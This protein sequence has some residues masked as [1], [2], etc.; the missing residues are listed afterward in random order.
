MSKHRTSAPR[1]RGRLALLAATLAVAA[2]TVATGRSVDEPPS[3]DAAAPGEP[4]SS[5]AQEAAAEAAAEAGSGAASAPGEAAA[6][7]PAEDEIVDLEPFVVTPTRGPRRLEQAPSLTSLITAADILE[8]Q[9]RT[10]PEALDELPGVMVQK[11]GHGQGSPFI[12]GFTGFRNLLLIDGIRLNNSVFRDGPNQYWNTI[13]PYSI[14]RLEVVKGPGSVLYG[15]DAIGGTVNVLTTGPLLAGEGLHVGGRGFYRLS[16]AER[17]H[18]Y[19]GSVE[20]VQ[21]G[22]VG[23]LV[24]GTFRDY[25][26]LETGR[27]R[28]P[29]TG[30]EELDFDAKLEWRID[31]GVRLV[32]AHQRVDID[33][34][35]RTHRTVFGRSFAGTTLGDEQRRVLDQNRDLTYAQ[36]RAE[37]LGGAIDSAVVSLSYQTQ[38]EQ[39]DR[40]RADGRRDVQGFDVDT[41]GVWAQLGSVTPIGRLTWGVEWY[42]D[43]VDSFRT[44]FAPDGSISAVR[45]QGPVADDATYDLVGAYVQNEI[46]IGE[47]LDLFL[48][49]R[50]TWARADA[51]RVQDPETGD[52]TSITEDF[53][54]LV[55]SARAV[56][57]PAGTEGLGF[58]GG[59][60]Q[61]FRAPNLSDLTRLDTARSDEIETPAPG[62][63]PERFLAFE[64]GVRYRTDTFAAEAAYYRTEIDDLIIRQPTGNLVEG[65]REVTK[66]NSGSGFVQGVELG[67]SWELHRGWT[68]G[69]SLSW[70]EG[71]VDTFPTS[72]AVL[73]REP[74]SRLMPTTGR[75]SLRWDA[76]D[77]R[78]WVEGLATLA[79]TQD[80]L[81]SRDISD[82]QRIP[83]GG[84]PGYA[85]YTL[86]GG[87]RADHGL[88]VTAALENLTDE[89]YRIH[90]SGV[91]EPGI[92]FILGVEVR[93]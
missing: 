85:V 39:R 80:E 28:L 81:S 16:T 47:D 90:G 68:L 69:G 65:D 56:W 72:D 18:T 82:T 34:A 46:P 37:D 42:R 20:I 22:T 71:E 53:D 26:D 45:I 30:Y 58:F 43:E 13:D 38:A 57:T 33:D 66:R 32:V 15:S 3:V 87:W 75:V 10:L 79:E 74:L 21:D 92:N 49:G 5:G 23:L 31:E 44:D 25:G 63:E 55:G 29:R 17:S 50:W 14:D 73:V 36:L 89:D 7:D 76:P 64:G 77:R 40:V 35:W 6:P 48:G 12:R 27:G 59:V 11:T 93:F 19:R 52:P 67:A 62:L 1:P 8:E 24:G 86:R 9:P 2:A 61:G 51:G 83:P 70:M 88:T 60:S 78:F 91:N 4:P 54:A 84:T 41:I